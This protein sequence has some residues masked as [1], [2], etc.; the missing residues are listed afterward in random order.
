MRAQCSTQPPAAGRMSPRWDIVV[1]KLAGFPDPG[2]RSRRS[3]GTSGMRSGSTTPPASVGPSWGPRRARGR[4]A[5][6]GARA[7][8]ACGWMTRIDRRA[9]R[10]RIDLRPS[11]QPAAR[12]E[13]RVRPAV[14]LPRRLRG[15]LRLRTEEQPR[16]PE[17]TRG[18]HAGRLLHGCDR[19][20]RLRPS[21]EAGV[22]HRPRPA[23]ISKRKVTTKLDAL[24]R[25]LERVPR[26]ATGPRPV[27]GVESG[28]AESM[29][30]ALD[31]PAY[32]EAV[33]AAQRE[34]YAGESYELCL[35]N[36]LSAAVGAADPLDIFA[37]QRRLQ[38]G[39]Y[40]ASFALAI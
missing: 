37:R 28:E 19:D 4:V 9:G 6:P 16:Q 3:S 7:S 32:L 2:G 8:S 24:C 15:V 12:T 34:L 30:W 20:R 1:A 38:P 27:V 31:R 39:P 17:P 11:S 18:G 26:L 23:R 33:A 22:R 25:R 35:T 10:G 21:I 14:R 36:R 40:G 13:G 29:D 5:D